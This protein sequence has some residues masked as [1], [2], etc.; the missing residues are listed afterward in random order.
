MHTHT[1]AA[2]SSH[3]AG[4]AQSFILFLVVVVVVFDVKYMCVVFG[5]WGAERVERTKLKNKK[6]Q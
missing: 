2:N 4:D 6:K 5:T 1:H 3:A